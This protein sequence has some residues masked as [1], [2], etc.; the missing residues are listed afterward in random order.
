MSPMK[1]RDGPLLAL[2][3]AHRRFARGWVGEWVNPRR[4]R[5][6]QRKT[7][8]LNG[9]ESKS[10]TT[11]NIKKTKDRKLHVHLQNLI[12]QHEFSCSKLFL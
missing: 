3:L 4:L 5:K 9:I 1:G 6:K 10:Y 11:Y 12:C 7:Y 2:L 8:T